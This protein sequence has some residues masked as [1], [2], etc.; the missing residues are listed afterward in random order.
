[1]IPFARSKSRYE[2]W[3][4]KQLGKD[5]VAVDL[6]DKNRLMKD[7]AF[8]FLRGTYWRWAEIILEVCPD[9]AAAPAVLAV[10]DIHLENFGTWRDVDGRLVW[11]INDFDEA[12]PMPY[13]IDLVR[14]AASA[15]LASGN[16]KSALAKVSDAI[17]EGYA[18]GLAAPNP[19]V[20]DR[21]WKQ[22]RSQVVVSD[23][24]RQKFWKKID[25]R[26]AERAPERFRKALREA[27]P[28]PGL[29]FDTARRI[30]GTG[31]LGRPRWIGVAEWRGA[32]VV[33]EA[34]ALLLSGWT[35]AHGKANEPIRAGDIA[36]GRYRAPDPWYRVK[37]GIVVRRISPNNRKI[38]VGT[39]KTDP[40]LG[41]S[42]LSAMGL[43][44]ANEH[45]G[46]GD[47]K[48]AID[49]D[50]KARKSGWLADRAGTAAAA[51]LE[52]FKAFKKH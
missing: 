29:S 3:L 50:L 13:A 9:L 11:G 52:D 20:L 14:L 37:N 33:R 41:S 31:S 45:L 40:L 46:T 1:M 5:L 26:E 51:V 2:S 39:K 15:A 6:A 12:A 28:E 19:V 21:D 42:M 27:M 38:E 34:K 22:L 32:P 24:A 18:N 30:A 49:R 8:V 35:L 4:R 36:S 25:A 23:E 16:G 48:A 44:L 17:L 47:A 7:S 10:G 43:A